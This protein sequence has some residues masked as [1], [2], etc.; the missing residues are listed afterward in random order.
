MFSTWWVCLSSVFVLSSVAFVFQSFCVWMH[1]TK[2]CRVTHDL[3]TTVFCATEGKQQSTVQLPQSCQEE[4][5]FFFSLFP[6]GFA[7]AVRTARRKSD[8]HVYSSSMAASLIKGTKQ[9]I[10]CIL[11]SFLAHGQR[12]ILMRWEKCY[13]ETAAV[14]WPI[15]N[16]HF[17]NIIRRKTVSVYACASSHGD[18]GSM[19]ACMCMFM[20]LWESEIH[21]GWE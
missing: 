11:L 19:R 10:V 5:I 12:E 2:L 13:T 17:L 20:C 21:G 1:R 4:L 6:W 9:H 3:Q 14:V 15:K 18:N 16:V 7:V 8:R